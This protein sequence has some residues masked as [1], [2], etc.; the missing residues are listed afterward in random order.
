MFEAT[1]SVLKSIISDGVIY[2]QWADADTAY[3]GITLFEFIF[4]FYL[5]IDI[6]KITYDLSQALQCKS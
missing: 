1:C 2:A 5:L 4:V 6:M 3:D